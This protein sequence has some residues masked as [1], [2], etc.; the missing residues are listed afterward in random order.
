LVFQQFIAAIIRI[1][2]IAW[3]MRYR[4]KWQ[5]SWQRLK[6]LWSHG[7]KLLGADMTLFFVFESPTVI[8]SRN[9]GLSATGT[10]SVVKNFSEIP[11][12]IILTSLMGVLFPA[13]SAMQDDKERRVRAITLSARMTSLILTPILFGIWALAEP[14]T[15]IVLG[16]KW[17]HAA[18]IL[19]VLCIAKL[20]M[21]PC[22]S[23]IP[24]LRG[25]GFTRELLHIAIGRLILTVGILY[26]VTLHGTLMD[27]MVAFCVIN[28]ITVIG[29]SA[30]VFKVNG[31]NQMDSFVQVMQP[32]ILAGVMAI[33]VRALYLT[34]GTELHVVLQLALFVPMGGAIYGALLWIFERE[35][36]MD[37]WMRLRQREKWRAQ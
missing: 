23:Y 21:S 26:A 37:L 36:V 29:Y 32:L 19:G 10:Y 8:I 11:N 4:P 33:I 16:E 2:G 30:Y 12:Q 6:E 20:L 1:T 9:L 17:M 27:A 31:Q 5:F 3:A 34:F 18:P 13:F 28:F 14:L 22:G 15:R 35:L 25:L 7:I 24:Y